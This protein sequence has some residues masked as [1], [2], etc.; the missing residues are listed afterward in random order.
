MQN[1]HALQI[2]GKSSVFG[3]CGEEGGWIYL[4]SKSQRTHRYICLHTYTYAVVTC[5]LCCSMMAHCLSSHGVVRSP[6]F[7]TPYT[8]HPT[9]YMQDLLAGKP[10][11]VKVT[12][13]LIAAGLLSSG[14][15]FDVAAFRDWDGF[16]SVVSGDIKGW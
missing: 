15:F 7:S 4:V 12:L 10:G 2:G 6:N 13:E 1:V 14:D 16:K 9:P 8:L 3:F 11:H 5:A